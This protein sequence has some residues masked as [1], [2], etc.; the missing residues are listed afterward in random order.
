M[1][2]R[3]ILDASR[4]ATEPPSLLRLAHGRD[5][6][7]VPARPSLMSPTLYPARL[8]AREIRLIHL[9]CSAHPNARLRL[10]LTKWAMDNAPA[11]E[12]LSY[13]WG[14][15]DT[16]VPVDCNNE[17]LSVTQNLVEALMARRKLM[18][19]GNHERLLWVDA[20]CINQADLVER[21]QQVQLM[22]EIFGKADTVWISLGGEDHVHRSALPLIQLIYDSCLD[23]ATQDGVEIANLAARAGQG[24]ALSRVSV[25]MID[26]AA[27][28]S[29]D[30]ETPEEAWGSLARLFARPYFERRWCVQEVVLA[31]NAWILSPNIPFPHLGTVA[32]WCHAHNITSDYFF[33]GPKAMNSTQC[34]VMASSARPSDSFITI[35]DDFRLFRATDPRDSVYAL[36][37]LLDKIDPDS[38]MKKDIVVNYER[39]SLVDVFTDVARADIRHTLT[40]QVLSYAAP[41][42]Y[43]D[44]HH[45]TVPGSLNGGVPTWAPRWDRPPKTG[46][47]ISPILDKVWTISG[48][49]END[50]EAEVQ[51]AYTLS[52]IGIQYDTVEA[53]FDRV[54]SGY[55][56]VP[57]SFAFVLDILDR[58]TEATWEA[59]ARSLALTMTAGRNIDNDVVQDLETDEQSQFFSDFLAWIRELRHSQAHSQT[60][61]LEPDFPQL[62]GCNAARG[63]A[64]RYFAHASRQCEGRRLF[65][66][67]NGSIGL[68]PELMH[69]MDAVVLLH[70]GQLPYVLRRVG[71]AWQLVGDCWMED[72]MHSE[73]FDVG[74]VCPAQ[75]KSIFHIL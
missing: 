53:V 67:G 50:I 22:G 57:G 13:V 23:L 37:G 10:R 72:I 33:F 14:S 45:D 61:H 59:G 39:K 64:H 18:R 51:N 43:P 63:Y 25:E 36:L 68:G 34:M 31:Q 7:V 28:A 47:M 29:R 58:L 12:A 73:F 6:D 71:D 49:P 15:A 48:Q 60:D 26:E 56:N 19:N 38:P 8:G 40:L 2:D 11:F 21:A 27:T 17:P 75:E 5:H 46:Y 32:Q 62:A 1:T 66:L 35:L 69:D 52:V 54:T 44:D 55:D 16:K 24:D 20:V 3:A 30:I 70:G 65:L 4:K 74:G 9:E 42:L 41:D